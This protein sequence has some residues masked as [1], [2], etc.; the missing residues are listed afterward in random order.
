MFHMGFIAVPENY[1]SPYHGYEDGKVE[2]IPGLWYFDESIGV[3]TEAE[4]TIEAF[5]NKH[6]TN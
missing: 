6:K 3:N 2:V 1:Q 5:L 4:K